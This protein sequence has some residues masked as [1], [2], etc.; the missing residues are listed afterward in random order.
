MRTARR[1][2][3]AATAA[4]LLVIQTAALA[5]PV[6]G[7]D[8]TY[9]STADFAKGTAVNLDT[10]GGLLRLSES[11]GTFPFIWI[12]LSD[13]G[14]IAKID[15]RTG[16]IL[17]EYQSAPDGVGRNPSRT[18]VSTDGS[19][20]AGNRNSGR[21]VHI[22]LTEMNQCVDR[23]GDGVIQTSGGYGDVLAWPAPAPG[24]P[25]I[26]T[27]TDECILHLVDT[28]GGD[29]RHVSVAPDGAIWVGSYSG[30][31]PRVFERLDPVTGAVTRTEGPFGCGGYGGLMDRNGVL[32]SATSGSLLLRFDTT[33]PVGPDNPRCLS[34]SNYGLALDQDG[35]VWV[36]EFGSNV[37]KVSPDGD[38]VLG[39]FNNGS[40]TSSQGLAIDGRGHAWISS[41][42][43]C[44]SSCGIGHLDNDGNLIGV[45]PTPTGAGST[46]IAV[47]ADGKI[48]AA[49]I[50]SSTA[51]RIDPNAGPV[52]SD[53]T[54]PVGAVDLTV[55]LPATPEAGLPLA[56]PYNY[57]DM[58]GR[59]LLGST[60][61]Q[62]SWTVV[63][64]GGAGASWGRVTFS[65]GLGPAAVAGTV[66]IE[67]RASETEAGLGSET[68]QKV[69]NGEIFN[70]D[71]RFLQVRLTLRP[72]EAG[73]SP[74][75]DSVRIQAHP[76][77]PDVLGPNVIR[78]GGRER[79]ATAVTISRDAFGAG[80]ADTVVLARSDVFADALAATP[81]A[82]AENAP[83]LITPPDQ[84]HPLVRDELTRVLAKGKTVLLVGGT[85]ALK[86]SV[87]Q[88]LMDLGYKVERHAGSDRFGTAAA[89]AE[90]LGNP[91]DL[92]LASGLDFPDAVAAGAAAGHIGGAVLLTA[93]E[94]LPAAT[95]EYLAAHASATR[96]AVGGP[97]AKADPDAE[98]LVGSNRFLTALTVAEELFEG[99][100]LVGIATGERFPDALTGGA[101]VA[102]RG[103][104]VLLSPIASLPSDVADYL[105]AQPSIQAAYLFG[106]TAALSAEVEQRVKQVFPDSP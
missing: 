83:L 32:W 66:E 2:A 67:V 50:N 30:G 87:A 42:L 85:E 82:V 95:T 49:N 86:P 98:P 93:G 103:G 23:N 62:G 100:P 45:V 106:G 73:E 46:G 36:N 97:A 31:T 10:S 3:L 88:A 102:A 71:G 15:T 58:T 34:V 59:V 81:L 41:S 16:E 22:G 33:Q 94:D 57:S 75:L 64:D 14:T 38:T 74:V 20:W 53:G 21:V 104:P 76:I 19:V 79:V 6:V 55:E 84:L 60:A 4:L 69:A 39:P 13:R 77:G 90:R 105:E 35:W 72:S 101:Y 65:E 40:T 12:A 37:R 43:S 29:A 1:I 89:I 56:R 11:G 96:Y 68:Y 7:K 9:D 18:T 51:T 44:F 5:A 48:W 54:T 25:E 27:A 91:D 80:E 78:L 92:L 28:V 99:P 24:D 8:V 61:P 17:G 63:Q 26:S 52:G 70:L 47:D